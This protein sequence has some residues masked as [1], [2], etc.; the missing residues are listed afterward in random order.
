MALSE[1]ASCTAAIT[2]RGCS[3]VASAGG[4]I[5]VL[6][7]STVP[8]GSLLQR[9]RSRE[10]ERERAREHCGVA[11]RLRSPGPA[12]RGTCI[13]QRTPLFPRRVPSRPRHRRVESLQCPRRPKQSR[14]G[15]RVA[16]AGAREHRS[17]AESGP[18]S[19]RSTAR[20]GP[21]D[22]GNCSL[23]R[24]CGLRR[25]EDSMV[26]AVLLPAGDVTSAV[27]SLSLASADRQHHS[28]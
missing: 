7:L 8:S 6:G 14:I 22:R 9:D 18:R 28:G 21:S 5:A 1:S 12:Q 20:D 4:A 26:R 3:I 17:T 11:A 13:T 25:I 10:R 23:L 27:R 15:A 16:S 24:Y 19:S 2:T